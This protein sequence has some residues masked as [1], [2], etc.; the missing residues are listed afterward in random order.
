MPGPYT[1]RTITASSEGLFKDRGSK[2]LAYAYPIASRDTVSQHMTS[3]RE[4]HSKGRHHCYAFRLGGQGQDYRISDDGEP[5]GSAGQPIY[6][7]LLSFELTNTLVAVVRY[8]GGTK[9]GIPGLINAYKSATIEAL[10]NANIIEKELCAFYV[11]ESNY[12]HSS[13]LLSAFK[14]NGI[15]IIQTDYLEQVRFQVKI[16]LADHKSLLD[17]ALVTA[18]K[19]QAPQLIEQL[20]MDELKIELLHC[21][22]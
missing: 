5:N 22:V 14:K 1:Y 12:D 7:Q 13:R 9:L 2:F 20:P 10:S 18:L 4:L 19:L 3:V 6:N 17:S 8:F 21:E 15:T 16:P 11:V